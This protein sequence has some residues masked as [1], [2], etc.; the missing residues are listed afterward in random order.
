MQ[1]LAPRAVYADF[2]DSFSDLTPSNVLTAFEKRTDVM[3]SITLVGK[4]IA[5][6]GGHMNAYKH[7]FII[8]RAVSAVEL[9]YPGHAPG[10]LSKAKLKRLRPFVSHRH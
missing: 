3:L 5:K 1:C 2:E 10:S 8:L 7:Q 6:S 4:F 9:P